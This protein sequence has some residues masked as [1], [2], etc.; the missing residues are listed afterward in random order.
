MMIPLPK[1]IRGAKNLPKQQEYLHNLLNVKG[2]LISR[3]VVQSVTAN[4]NGGEPRGAFEYLGVY[5]AVF[6]QKLY[7][8]TALVEVG[9]ILGAGQIA[10]DG[11]FNHACIVTGA[12]GANY[13]LTPAGALAVIADPD[14]PACRD[15][16]FIDGRFVFIPLDGGPAIW[17]AVGNGG[18]VGPLDFFD[19]ESQPDENRVVM[20]IRNDV[21]IGGTDTFERFRN[22][23]PVTAP[24]VR[25]QNAVISVGYVGGKVLTKDSALFVGKD[26]AAGYGIFVFSEGT[27]QRISDQAIDEMLNRDYTPAQLAAVRSQRFNWGGVDCYTFELADRT[28]I[29][30][31]GQWSYV[32]RGIVGPRQ[33][34][35]FG[36]FNATL[37]DGIWYVQDE[38][39]GLG[40]LAAGT[41]DSFG[42]LQREI[43][44]F[45]RDAEEGVFAPAAMQLGVSNGQPGLAADEATVGL[46]VSKN[47]KLW[48]VMKYRSLSAE[49]EYDK[50]L[51]WHPAGGFG[52]FDGFM[53]ICIYTTASVDIAADSLVATA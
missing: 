32:S 23:G 25:V 5:Y 28:L 38:A 35:A 49:G 45:A 6:G 37:H 19:A 31:D 29:F 20:N 4:P 41:E 47:G 51:I 43:V 1:T 48:G 22:S 36:F 2:R 7:R 21:F 10:V 53:G 39:G 34:A 8:T 12:A 50:Q 26:K 24:F 13:T 3:P 30:Q 11:G 40:K 15:V 17:S 9:D 44:T 27:A 18:D 16:V 33:L 42:E 52:R 14:L 46:S